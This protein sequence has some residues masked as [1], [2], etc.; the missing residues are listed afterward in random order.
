MVVT[1]F[2]KV[3]LRF[4]YHIVFLKVCCR[5]P[6]YII[7]SKEK[8]DSAIHAWACPSLELRLCWAD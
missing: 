1:L 7:Q 3:K 4:F 8:M 6:A 5:R 2:I